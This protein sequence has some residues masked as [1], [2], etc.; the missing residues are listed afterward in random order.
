MLRPTMASRSVGR[1][2]RPLSMPFW[3][4]A[5]GAVASDQACT[6]LSQPR[7]GGLFLVPRFSVGRHLTHQTLRVNFH[8]SGVRSL[9]LRD[10]GTYRDL[11]V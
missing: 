1:G 7:A 2:V 5:L 10:P 11:P 8:L 3:V 4:G 6:S 9:E